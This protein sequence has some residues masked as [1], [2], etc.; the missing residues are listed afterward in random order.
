MLSDAYR[1][2]LGERPCVFQLATITVSALFGLGD[3][4][5]FSRYETFGWDG[6]FIGGAHHATGQE[7]TTPILTNDVGERRYFTTA[8]WLYEAEVA[9]NALITWPRDVRVNGPGMFGAILE[10]RGHVTTLARAA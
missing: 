8:N 2:L 1:D 9:E 6:C 7:Q 5:G 3:L 10:G 4:L